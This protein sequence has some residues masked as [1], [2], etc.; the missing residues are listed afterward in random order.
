MSERL[1]R[2]A[3]IRSLQLG[4]TKVTYVP[5]GVAQLS[6]RHWFPDTT[7][8]DWA[9]TAAY[10]DEAGYLVASLGG[11]LVERA[12]RALL[13]DS[14]LGPVSAPAQPGS[15]VGA[16]SGGTLLDN[17]THLGRPADR[18]EAVAFT[19][20]H[21]DHVG[22][23][24]HE[25]LSGAEFLF[26]EA[27]WQHRDVVHHAPPAEVLKEMEPR[28]RTVTDGEEIF[29]GVRVLLTPGHTPG[30]AAYVISGD[31]GRRVIAFGDAFHTPLQMAHPEWR[32]SVDHDAE[33]AIAF[34][35]RL[36]EQL[37]EPGTVGFG[38]HFA[39]VVFGRVAVDGGA[40]GWVPADE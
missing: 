5:D 21:G 1:S 27:E 39:D 16:M 4:E 2:P 28:V 8:A 20:L 22:W 13:I 24:G 26:S 10:L 17:L 37:A 38:I 33:G 14:G 30:H 11:L 6:P 34:R 15:P 35:R 7:D 12:D 19:H 3:G 18:I 23:V 31:D 36:V 25:A 9:D 32:V 40:P 29:P